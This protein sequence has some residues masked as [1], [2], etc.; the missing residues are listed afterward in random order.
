[1]NRS[2]DSKMCTMK[3]EQTQSLKQT[4]MTIIELYPP[5]YYTAYNL[6][7]LRTNL[8][9]TCSPIIAEDNLISLAWAGVVT[10]SLKI[11]D[12][13]TTVPSCWGSLNMSIPIA[14]VRKIGMDSAHRRRFCNS[15]MSSW[16][17]LYLLLFFPF[18]IHF[19]TDW[20]NITFVCNCHIYFKSNI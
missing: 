5:T 9:S 20:L 17:N 16:F 15:V 14:N 11:G 10:N 7:S 3:L 8:G 18:Y 12:N 19:L 6:Y 4:M 2:T 13:R 1:M